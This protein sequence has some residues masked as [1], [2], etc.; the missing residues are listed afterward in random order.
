M[1]SF[2]C[3][4]NTLAQA[5][6][7]VTFIKKFDC[8][9]INL[10]GLPILPLLKASICHMWVFGNFIPGKDTGW[11]LLEGTGIPLYFGKIRLFLF[12]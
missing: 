3:S 11:G 2:V 8:S 7:P 5:T 4:E 1:V 12:G 10:D 9:A 6:T